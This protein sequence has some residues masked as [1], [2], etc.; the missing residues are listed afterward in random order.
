M[1]SRS[2]GPA[3]SAWK[4]MRRSGG[5]PQGAACGL[6]DDMGL[7]SLRKTWARKGETESVLHVSFV[8]IT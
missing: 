2:K 1:Q 6:G 5:Q 4:V 8:R 3:A 7:V